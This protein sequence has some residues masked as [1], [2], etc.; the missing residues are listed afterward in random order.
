MNAGPAHDMGLPSLS[1][2]V[3]TVPL[4]QAHAKIDSPT[5][6]NP[7]PQ[8]HVKTRRGPSA[9]LALGEDGST[10][11]DHEGCPNVEDRSLGRHDHHPHQGA[12]Y[13]TTEGSAR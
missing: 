8:A 9:A 6:T 13:S 11:I 3:K 2:P 4:P 1:N 10:S 12:Y 5:V 7:L